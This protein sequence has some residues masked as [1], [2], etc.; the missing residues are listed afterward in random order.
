[1]RSDLIARVDDR[2]MAGTQRNVE[3][4]RREKAARRERRALLQ[5]HR[6]TE[7]ASALK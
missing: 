5:L 4:P 2:R 1:M 3:C 6:P 7:A